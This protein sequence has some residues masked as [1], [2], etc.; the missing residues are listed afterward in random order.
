[1][2]K[3]LKEFQNEFVGLNFILHNGRT[4]ASSSIVN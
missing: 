3:I 2:H 4:A 1:M